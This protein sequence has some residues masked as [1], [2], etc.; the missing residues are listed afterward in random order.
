MLAFDLLSDRQER[1]CLA[2]IIG[3]AIVL[4][5]GS[6]KT[7]TASVTIGDNYCT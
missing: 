1:C 4:L 7:Q 6:H 2:Q 3:W 5:K